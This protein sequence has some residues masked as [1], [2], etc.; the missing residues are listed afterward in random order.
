MN[1]IS[2]RIQLEELEKLFDTLPFDEREKLIA[3]GIQSRKTHDKD[4][5]TDQQE[6]ARML[7]QLKL[8]IKFTRIKLDSARL[9]G[10]RMGKMIEK[11]NR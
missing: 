8:C 6:I 10:R 11:N 3:M 1:E 2:L 7:D 9:E 5:S 4:L